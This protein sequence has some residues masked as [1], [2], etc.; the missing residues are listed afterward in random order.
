MILNYNSNKE[1]SST[2]RDRPNDKYSSY[3]SQDYQENDNGGSYYNMDG[4][5]KQNLLEDDNRY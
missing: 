2:S 4:N 3:S 1:N 5:K